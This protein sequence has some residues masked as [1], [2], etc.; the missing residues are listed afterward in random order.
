MTQKDLEEV[1]SICMLLYGMLKKYSPQFCLKTIIVMLHK[2]KHDGPSE[3]MTLCQKLEPPVAN[4]SEAIEI[5]C[6]MKLQLI[7]NIYSCN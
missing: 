7:I 5:K 4:E 2:A 3:R 6:A 1:N